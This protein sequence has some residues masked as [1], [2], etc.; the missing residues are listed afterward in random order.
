MS[1]FSADDG[2]TGFMRGMFVLVNY[3][4]SV[5]WRVPIKLKSACKVSCNSLSYRLKRG[6]VGLLDV[7]MG[8][9]GGGRC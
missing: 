5:L 4:G 3:E 1:R 9:G 7:G 2:S 8:R 6:W